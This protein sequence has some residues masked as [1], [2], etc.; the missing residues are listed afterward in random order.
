MNL[1]VFGR[2]LCRSFFSTT[3]RVETTGL[4]NIPKEGPVLLCSNHIH[5]FDP[6]FLGSYVPRKV[7]YMAK[8]E[9]F[10][11]PLLGRMITAVGAFPVK[12][13]AGDKQALK[14]GLKILKEGEALG[15]FPEGT[16]SKDGKLG[17]GLAGAGF[18]ALRTDAV[19][20]PCAIIG[21]YK[22]FSKLRVIYGEPLEM[23]S[24]RAAKASSGEV[25]DYIMKAIAELLH[26]HK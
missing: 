5:N 8:A 25:T 21:S 17:K 14:L 26:K 1:Y 9:L 11:V 24:L 22:P 16:R 3:Y 10:K 18:F 2:G 6:P 19:V 20:I 15:L 12:R 7:H 13:G 4:E 23:E